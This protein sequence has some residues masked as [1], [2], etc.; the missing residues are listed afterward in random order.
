MADGCGVG[1]EVKLL[2]HKDAWRLLNLESINK[3]LR[4]L[5]SEDHRELLGKSEECLCI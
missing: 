5:L 3:D 2:I 1:K 4:E